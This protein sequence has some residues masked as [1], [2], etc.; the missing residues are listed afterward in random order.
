MPTPFVQHNRIKLCFTLALLKIIWVLGLKSRKV[1]IL[2]KKRQS[3][4]HSCHGALHLILKNICRTY[5]TL[6]DLLAWNWTTLSIAITIFETRLHGAKS[7]H[8]NASFWAI[9]PCLQYKDPIIKLYNTTAIH[10]HA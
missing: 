3:I 9:S 4:Y 8:V 6:L 10:Q 1:I 5:N 2:M 7:I